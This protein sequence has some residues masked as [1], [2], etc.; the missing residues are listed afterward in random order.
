MLPI[1]AS[2]KTL[3][4]GYCSSAYMRPPMLGTSSF[5]AIFPRTGPAGLR[6][7]TRRGG[8]SSS[9]VADAGFSDRLAGSGRAGGGVSEPRSGGGIESGA[10]AAAG[11]GPDRDSSSVLSILPSVGSTCGFAGVRPAIAMSFA[12]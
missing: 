1:V 4:D 12:I 11:A 10:E 5:A 9:V 7:A 6:R 3:A 8:G 2:R